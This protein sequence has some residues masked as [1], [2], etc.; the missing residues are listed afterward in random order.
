M[1]SVNIIYILVITALDSTLPIAVFSS[2]LSSKIT[3]SILQPYL[4]GSNLL[5]A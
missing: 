4:I 5:P 2:S 3:K 1:S